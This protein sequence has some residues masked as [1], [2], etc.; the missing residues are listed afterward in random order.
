MLR[1]RTMHVKDKQAFSDAGGTMRFL[2]KP[3]DIAR[4]W[5][6]EGCRLIHIVDVDAIKGTPTNL[7]I[8]DNLTFFVNVEVECAP[9]AQM[10]AKLLSL[11]CRVVLA[12]TAESGVIASGMEEKRLLVAII[13]KSYKGDADGFHDVILEDADERSVARFHALGRRVIIYQKDEA[14]I[15]SKKLLFGIISS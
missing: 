4:R 1:I 15:K 10:V 7:D 3:I 5:K 12:P 14:K 13:R 2:G 6:D 9:Q 11:K 8:Y